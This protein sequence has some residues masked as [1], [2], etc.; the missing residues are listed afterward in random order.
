MGSEK[1]IGAGN[2]QGSRVS[3]LSTDALTPQ[4]L[5]AELLEADARE[6]R[7]Y[8]LGAS[9]DG[10]FNALHGTFRISQADR[11]WLLVLQMLLGKLGRRSWIYREGRRNVWVLEISHELDE[12]EPATRR[13]MALSFAGISTR[14]EVSHEIRR[15][16]STSS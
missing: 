13:E 6:T 2:Q 4:R 11:R 16:G 12:V 5:H 10:T 14:R 8:L 1:P 3:V 7:A 9:R 15:L